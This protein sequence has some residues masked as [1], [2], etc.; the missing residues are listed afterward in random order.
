MQGSRDAMMVVRSELFDRLD[1]LKQVS[2]SRSPADFDRRL[3]GIISLA[4]AYGLQP[5]ARLGEALRQGGGPA[6]LYFER[7]RDAIR[8][9]R[10]DEEAAQ[11]MLASVSVRLGS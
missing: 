6:P 8:C 3:E 11:A 5:V 2:A 7:M 9:D 1:R 4:G 10:A